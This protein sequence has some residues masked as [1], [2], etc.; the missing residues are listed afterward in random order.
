MNTHRA[1]L[2]SAALAVTAAALGLSACATIIHSPRQE[3]GIASTPSG[4]TVSI[5]NAERGKTPLV[6]KL[7]RK[8]EHVLRIEM[9]GYQP[10]EATL[11]RKVSGWVWGN[12]VFGGLVGLAVDAVSGSMYKLSPEQ[13]SA[14]LAGGQA[15]VS[16]HGDGLYVVAVLEPRPDWVKVAQLQRR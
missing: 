10:F 2:R 1:V 16:V 13:V 9:A 4:G 6:A 7:S 14:S 15:A 8:D 5:D 11:T 3:V 12:L